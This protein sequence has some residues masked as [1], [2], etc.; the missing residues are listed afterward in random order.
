LSRRLVIAIAA[1]IGLV[2]GGYLGWLNW[3]ASQSRATQ[4]SVSPTAHRYEQCPPYFE[5]LTDVPGVDFRHACGDG[6]K[7][8]MP[9]QL[10]SGLALFDYDRDGKLDLFVV[11]GMPAA[12][13]PK[14]RATTRASP[15]SRLFRQEE[16]G[17]F[18]D[19]T[20]DAGLADDQPYGMGAAV[21]DINNDGWPDLYITK[22]GLDKLYL[23]R[24]GKFE[25]IT[26]AAG[27]LNPRWGTSAA[28]VDYDRDGWLDLYVTNY[29]DY[30]PSRRCSAASGRHDFCS[31]IAFSDVPGKLFHNRT[32][33]SPDGAVR[34]Q[35]VSLESGIDAKPGPGLGVVVE[36]FSGDAWPDIYVANDQKAN[37]LWINQRDG[38]FVEE[39]IA[40]GAAYDRAGRPQASMGVTCGDVDGDGRG[41][42]FMT[43]FSGEYSTLYRQLSTGIFEDQTIERGLGG[44]IP[45]TGFGTALAD[46]DLDGDPDLL[47]ANGRVLRKE[48]APEAPQDPQAFWIAYA[49]RNQLYVNDGQ[50]D[51]SE[52]DPATQPF[53]QGEHVAR[54]LAIGDLDD[55]GDLDVVTTEVDGPARLYRNVAPRRG[56]WLRVKALEPDL[57][58]RDAYGAAVTVQIAGR[59][60]SR[61]VSPAFSYASSNDP[62]VHFGL[63]TAENI[64]SV[65]VRWPNG[66]V[67]YFAGGDADRELK[68][69]HGRGSAP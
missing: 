23:N 35:D 44:T 48:G 63:G 50:G 21:G 29:V 45:F 37:F 9:E 33:Q 42:L 41:D 13:M 7:Y 1:A 14:D 6:G 59:T 22:Y 34:F 54:G 66:D 36:D 27:T 67:E 28:F 58:G 4:S 15:T 31:P 55:E 20:S 24:A 64:V 65:S 53:C 49:E 51:F 32:G 3:R 25:D 56:H 60:L 11:Q 8:F 61:T 47:V 19:V 69:E 2:G 40:S 46:L 62:R 30:F 38:R 5:E 17:R 16:Y 26:E 12:A 52:S 57:G 10:G 43:H 39:A 68:L 18:R